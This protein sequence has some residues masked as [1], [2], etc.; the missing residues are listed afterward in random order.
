MQNICVFILVWLSYLASLSILLR[1]GV[2]AVMTSGTLSLIF[3]ATFALVGGAFNFSKRR[4]FWVTNVALLCM[5][6][7]FMLLSGSG[8]LTA[9]I[10]G[11]PTWV[12]GQPTTLAFVHEGLF[13]IFCVLNN[14]MGFATCQYLSRRLDQRRLRSI[15]KEIDRLKGEI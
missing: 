1:P 5:S 10:A 8:R 2:G 14:F 7:A 13:F 12:S 11:R 9:N 4:A 6:L 3:T 15:R